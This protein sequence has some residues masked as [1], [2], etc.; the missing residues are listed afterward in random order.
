MATI[1][2]SHIAMNRTPVPAHVSPG[3]DTQTNPPAME[4]HQWTVAAALARNSSAPAA[5][6]GSGL[7]AV[8]VAHPALHVV[9]LFVAAL[10]HQVQHVVGTD[11]VQSWVRHHDRYQA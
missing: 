8:V 9:G 6:S 1:I 2:T 11:D 3:I 7:V 5:R 10:G 4:R